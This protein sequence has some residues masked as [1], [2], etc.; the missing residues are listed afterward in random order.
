MSRSWES[1][2]LGET[3]CALTA[4]A[5]LA[6]KG[7]TVR[8]A[9]GRTRVWIVTHSQVVALPYLGSGA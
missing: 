5:F 7:D 3:D 9:C 1:S 2:Q 6:S 4:N 8:P